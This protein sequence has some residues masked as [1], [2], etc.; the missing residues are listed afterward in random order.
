MLEINN[1]PIPTPSG[2]QVGIMD[3]SNAERNAQ[4]DMLIDRIATKRKIE[5]KWNHLSPHE[6][7][8]VLQVINN[9]YFFVKYPDPLTGQ[10]ETKTFYVGDRTT[11]MY[12]FVDGTPV[13]KDISF[14]FI[15]K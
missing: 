1:I 10:F 15:E 2:F 6:L 7:S 3:L 11:P 9:V 14:N 13:W 8:T 5:L 4:G 12:S